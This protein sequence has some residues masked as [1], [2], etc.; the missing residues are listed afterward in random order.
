[1]SDIVSRRRCCLSH[2]CSL[3]DDR[4]QYSCSE[5]WCEHNICYQ[6]CLCVSVQCL[7][8]L[9]RSLLTVCIG[10]VVPNQ[11]TK[12][13]NKENEASMLRSTARAVASHSSL[14][15]WKDALQ[16]LSCVPSTSSYPLSWIPGIWLQ[17]LEG[18]LSNCCSP[19]VP[20]TAAQGLRVQYIVTFDRLAMVDIVVSDSDSCNSE[21]FFVSNSGSHVWTYNQVTP[22]S[23][24]TVVLM[25]NGNRCE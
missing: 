6:Q 16:N 1:M 14:T 13:C 11:G 4:M 9:T 8:M 15:F 25:Y 22:A 21:C 3:L 7:E 24:E 2:R 12:A 10:S 19:L 5:D 17:W 23:L 18:T 20:R